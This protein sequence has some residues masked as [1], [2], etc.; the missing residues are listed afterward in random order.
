MPEKRK[1]PR[2]DCQME[3]SIISNGFFFRDTLIN[4]SEEGA[5][6]EFKSPV[7]LGRD[8]LLKIRVGSRYLVALG[9][10]KWKNCSKRRA[11]LQFIYLP[12]S[13]ERHIRSLTRKRSY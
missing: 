4:L 10:I 2:L 12:R 11:G 6:V 1:F 7:R 8:I 9:D 13:L 5:Q 3:V